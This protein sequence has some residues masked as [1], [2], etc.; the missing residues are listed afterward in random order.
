MGIGLQAYIP[1]RDA[2]LG[3]GATIWA[4]IYFLVAPCFAF[5]ESKVARDAVMLVSYT[6]TSKLLKRRFTNANVADQL[7]RRLT[8]RGKSVAQG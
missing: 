2:G 6:R 5:P 3:L 4:G 7:V 1:G 8:S